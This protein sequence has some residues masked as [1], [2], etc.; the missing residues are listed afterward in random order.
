[1]AELIENIKNGKCQLI[2]KNWITKD[3]VDV[4]DVYQSINECHV[5]TEQDLF[6][7]TI[8]LERLKQAREDIQ[9]ELF[10]KAETR[11]MKGFN[12]AINIC[13]RNLDRLIGSEGVND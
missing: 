7:N 6:T 12:D 10:I 8:S 1:M 4:K 13:L 9:S 2:N 3:L 11:Y 5:F